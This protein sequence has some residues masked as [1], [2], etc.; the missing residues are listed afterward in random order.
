MTAPS[1]IDPVCPLVGRAAGVR[2]T[3]SAVR[4]LLSTL[5]DTLMS[6]EADAICGAPTGQIPWPYRAVQTN[7]SWLFMSRS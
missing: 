1:S 7:F 3:G 5:V 2:V 4:R 6:A